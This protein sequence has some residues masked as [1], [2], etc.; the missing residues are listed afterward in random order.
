[1]KNMMLLSFFFVILNITGCDKNKNENENVTSTIKENTTTVN[2]YNIN[3]LVHPGNLELQIGFIEK[4]YSLIPK[5]KGDSIVSYEFQNCDVDLHYDKQGN[6]DVISANTMPNCPID[7]QFGKT[8]E[9]TIEKLID[10]DKKNG[11]KSRIL[12]ECIET[13]GHTQDPEII[14]LNPGAAYNR[15]IHTAFASA[16]VEGHFEWK[17]EIKK[18]LKLDNLDDDNVINCTDKFDESAIHL[19]KKGA[20]FSIHYSINNSIYLF[21]YPA[22]C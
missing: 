2:K 6:V 22:G 8:S 15:N 4:K 18:I 7:T 5:S 3:D 14:Y 21:D 1:M 20:I 16:Q 17:N 9:L 10:L 12:V 13:C 19:L 11:I